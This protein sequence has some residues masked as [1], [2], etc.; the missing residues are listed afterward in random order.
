VNKFIVKDPGQ[1]IDFY[2]AQTLQLTR[3][4]IKN[5]IQSGQ[6]TVN[7][8]PTKPAYLLSLHDEICY[9]KNTPVALPLTQEAIPLDIIYED[10][11]LMVINKPAGLI[12]HPVGRKHQSGTLVNA[13]LNHTQKLTKL[14]GHDRPGLV[15]RLDKET[16]GLLLIAKTDE[17]YLNLKEQFKKHLVKKA[18]YALVKGQIKQDNLLIDKPILRHKRQPLKMSVSLQEKAKSAITEIQV[19][20]RYTTKTLVKVKPKTGRTHQIRVHLAY[21]GYP[22]IG[23]YQY[24]KKASKK[25]LGQLLQAYF[26]AFTHPINQEQMVFEQPMSARLKARI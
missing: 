11:Y 7:G 4:H 26:L 10:K 1:R 22:V 9:P 8:E 15:H 17:A 18:Y 2:L 5:L 20:K 13:L 21:L 3:T 6:I 25:S 14:A 23:D 19:L 16:E 24:D 12:C